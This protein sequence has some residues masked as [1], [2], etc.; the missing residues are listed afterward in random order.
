[1]TVS[2]KSTTEVSSS[3]ATTSSGTT[4][5]EKSTTERSS[6]S[7]TTVKSKSGSVSESIPEEDESISQVVEDVSETSQFNL[8]NSG[9]E[10]SAG[11]TRHRRKSWETVVT[12]T[13]KKDASPTYIQG[14]KID[15][16]V[17]PLSVNPPPRFRSSTP[18]ALSPFAAVS[19]R[20]PRNSLE[21]RK[22]LSPNARSPTFSR[23]FNFS[24]SPPIQNWNH[25]TD[26]SENLL[27]FNLSDV[28]A[29]IFEASGYSGIFNPNKTPESGSPQKD[30]F[31][32]S[33]GFTQELII[34]S[35][36][37]S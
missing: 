22:S 30:V 13:L 25:G 26:A 2:E 5:S 15:S 23:S 7:T 36:E 3:S 32:W 34:K 6:S 31:N 12:G 29:P 16:D 18:P 10:S 14:E 28:A 9:F 24:K 17:A 1:A 19:P 8:S 4:V 11:G 33:P 21:N 35:N 27:D 37:N 20:S